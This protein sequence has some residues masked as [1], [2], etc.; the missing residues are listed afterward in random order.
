MV[1]LEKIPNNL[2]LVNLS[3]CLP[4]FYCS[5]QSLCFNL[6]RKRKNRDGSHCRVSLMAA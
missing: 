3:V 4:V 1:K 2:T 6:G 5:D